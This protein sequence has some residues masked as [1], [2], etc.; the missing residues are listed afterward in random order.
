MFEDVKDYLFSLYSEEARFRL[1]SRF[2]DFFGGK[3]SQWLV[4]FDSQEASKIGYSNFSN[5][6]IF[7][8]DCTNSASW[9]EDILSLD[10][11]P[12]SVL[13]CL[14]LTVDDETE[15]PRSKTEIMRF[16]RKA[17]LLCANTF[18]RNHVLE[19]ALLLAE[20][21]SAMQTSGSIP[22]ETPS[23]SLAKW[24]LKNDRQVSLL[25]VSLYLLFSSR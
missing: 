1:V 24:L 2:I 5:L 13:N 19:E 8:R 3:V 23:R 21:A 12:S 7:F 22:S 4:R 9:I 11:P 17:L 15:E 14:K 6:G 20:E 16:L 10:T 18:P 25:D